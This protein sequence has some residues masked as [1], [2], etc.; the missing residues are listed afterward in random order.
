MPQASAEVSI[1][2]CTRDRPG[3]LRRLLESLRMQESHYTREVL[4][5]NNGPSPIVG[6]IHEPRPGLSFARNTGIRSASGSVIVFVD[7]DMIAPPGWLATLL[8]PVLENGH[9][10]SIGLTEPMKL[11]TDAEQM[12]EAYGGHGYSNTAR[13]FAAPWLAAQH[14]RLPMWEVGPL[15][16]SAIRRDIFDRIGYFDEA[17]GAGT[18][19]GSWEDFE[20][21]YRLLRSGETIHVEP[22]AQVRH[23]HREDIPG[24]AKQLCAYR[25][26]EVAFCI[27]VFARHRDWRAL[28]HLLL[29]IPLWRAHLTI[30]ECLR[31]L[32]G[33]RQFDFA[34]MARETWAYLSA[35]VALFASLRRKRELSNR[36]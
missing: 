25:R 11:E 4:V 9:A 6:A 10:V 27:L 29:W 8:Q 21:T 17:L 5:V 20:L 15:G 23:A 33:H 36:K 1:V 12:F 34:V 22:R 19:V 32:R 3:E 2:V 16:N 13:T 18:P 24:L 14:W 7:D 31:R 28:T 35:P 26:G 30:Q